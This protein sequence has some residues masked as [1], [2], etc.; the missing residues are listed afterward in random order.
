MRRTLTRLAPTAAT[1]V[2]NA[3]SGS[4]G[5]QRPSAVSAPPAVL[6]TLYRA[7]MREAKIM[8][9]NPLL[10]TFFPI[11]KSMQPLVSSDNSLSVPN[12]PS[13]CA[14]VR[15][16]FR[17][18]EGMRTAGGGLT[19][20]FDLL[21]RAK[22]HNQEVAQ[23]L[24][25]GAKDRRRMMATLRD[26]APTDGSYYAKPIRGPARDDTK[27]PQL[28]DA[29]VGPAAR[30]QT[31]DAM[32]FPARIA[33]ARIMD[34]VATRRKTPTL[35]LHPG[36]GLVAHP[37][38]SSHSDRRVMIITDQTPTSTSALVLDMMY[39]YPLSA[40]NPMF[41]EVFWG[42]EV[43]NGG[44]LHVDFTMPP[45]A[46]IGVL[47]TLAPAKNVTSDGVLSKGSGAAT[48]SYHSA[49]SRW[50][51][52]QHGGQSSDRGALGTMEHHELLCKPLIRG[53]LRE[54][55]SLEPTLYYSKVEALPYLAQLAAGQPR[56]QVRLYWGCM[57]WTTSQINQEVANGHWIPVQLSP[58]FFAGYPL[59]GSRDG[60]AGDPRQHKESDELI[61]D[62]LTRRHHTATTSDDRFPTNEVLDTARALRLKHHNVDVVP[63]QV[64]PP[65]QPLCRR[66]P[67]WDQIM[68]SLGGEYEALVGAS[69]PF[70][71]LQDGLRSLPSQIVADDDLHG[72]SSLLPMLF[73]HDDDNDDD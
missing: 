65:D 54:D 8:D 37:L 16:S 49:W 22:Y 67:L 7:M 32:Q 64:F 15:S 6:R 33:P 57:R 60:A 66:E 34:H 56:S 10:K 19:A 31:M 3:T 25:L 11:P 63:P 42:H 69:N 1:S 4:A 70:A 38:S 18:A 28:T 35:Q 48:G 26:A 45:T 61:V 39:S 20:A 14:I 5:E 62:A 43:F 17:D 53:S 2:G 51:N 58:T 27:P 13:Y 52:L 72:A 24:N 36:M 68:L 55:G 23:R 73:G 46:C 59:R 40:G 41:P 30:L 29:D 12:G 47:H 21:Q 71:K 44:S 9:A 50:M